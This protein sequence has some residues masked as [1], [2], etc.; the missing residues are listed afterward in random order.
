MG[1]RRPLRW[2]LMRPSRPP[3]AA[4]PTKRVGRPAPPAAAAAASSSASS[5]SMAAG[6]APTA[7]SSRF[8]TW[9]MQQ[10]RR[11]KITAGFSRISRPTLSSGAS[12]AP[13]IDSPTAPLLLPPAIA[14]TAAISSPLFLL[15]KPPF[16]FPSQVLRDR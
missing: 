1:T 14:A 5:S 10:P 3:T 6:W 12:S 4:P 2:R 7:A 16:P 15:P 9:L 11:L 13:S 8:I